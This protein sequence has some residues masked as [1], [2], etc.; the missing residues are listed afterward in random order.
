MMDSKTLL[1]LT[2]ATIMAFGVA[3]C[4][5]GSDSGGGGGRYVE[6][7]DPT[8]S[9]LAA[10]FRRP[11]SEADAEAALAEHVR[12]SAFLE[13][14]PATRQKAGCPDRGVCTHRL[15]LVHVNGQG[16]PVGD[17]PSCAEINAQLDRQSG[18]QVAVRG[19]TW[20]RRVAPC[21]A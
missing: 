19:V 17:P 10:A 15:I 4:V 1:H 14:Y 13:Q 20:V 9:A 8:R 11:T 7:L 2:A 5:T 21:A 12:T 16:K 3:G 6:A 18:G